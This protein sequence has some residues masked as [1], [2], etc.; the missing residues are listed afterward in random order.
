M[1]KPGLLSPL[2]ILLLVLIS[3]VNS[4]AVGQPFPCPLP[5]FGTVEISPD[6]QLKGPGKNIDSIDFWE[7]PDPANTLLLVTAKNNSLVEVWKYPF[8]GNGQSPLHHSTFSR[9]NANGIIVDQETD[10]MYISVG[11]PACTVSV[12]SLP[13]LEFQMNFNRWWWP[14][15]GGEPN[16]TLL[17]LAD[18]EKRLYVSANDVVQVHDPKTGKY[19]YKFYPEK[20][21]ETMAADRFYQRLYIPDEND[22]TGVYAYH[23]D[24]KPY[25]RNGSNR[26]GEG[27]FQK[28]G[29]GIIIYTCTSDGG[30]DNGRGFIVVS[31]QIR[32]Q[33]EFEFFDRE[34]WDHLGTLKL[35]G[36]SNTDGIAS[37]QQPLPDYPLG[38]FAA[39]N[40]DNT[41]A[42][43]GWDVIF[44]E[45]GIKLG[46][47]P[48]E[49]LKSG[50][51][52]Q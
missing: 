1:I 27:V 50:K 12:F 23:P 19:L 17:N 5:P 9:S 45:I 31:D 7:A 13:G 21:L 37:T 20:G 10:L 51:T 38:I 25:E 26:F 24:G 16:L 8:I 28:D 22:H 44:R 18:G 6:F 15:Y 29:E 14:D 4:T 36:V 48:A 52:K 11:K 49:A 33:T 46:Q 35:V 43:I 41:T 42:G 32:E 47:I 39:V 40:D 34:S 2:L 30:T 3:L